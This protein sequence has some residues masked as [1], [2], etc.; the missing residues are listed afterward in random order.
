M[1]TEKVVVVAPKKDD[2]VVNMILV[3]TIHVQPSKVYI[4]L[5]SFVF[6]NTMIFHI[7]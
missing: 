6:V 2:V 1:F 3:V 4:H 7:A 5:S